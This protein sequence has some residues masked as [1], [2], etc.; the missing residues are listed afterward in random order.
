MPE[1]SQ[2][3]PPHIWELVK[4]E[5]A[6]LEKDVHRVHPGEIPLYTL[7]TFC[8]GLTPVDWLPQTDEQEFR[9]QVTVGCSTCHTF[10]RMS[11]DYDNVAEFISRVLK[12]HE[13]W[14]HHASHN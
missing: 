6:R 4:T 12:T 7:C 14:Y 11:E 3:I 5:H 10:R 8:G 2:V 13:L 1:A 9:V